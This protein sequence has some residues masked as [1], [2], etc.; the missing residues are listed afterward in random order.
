MKPKEHLDELRGMIRDTAVG[1]CQILQAYDEECLVGFMQ[2]SWDGF[3]ELC[4][5]LER[6]TASSACKQSDRSLTDAKFE[7]HMLQPKMTEREAKAKKCLASNWSMTAF[8]DALFIF[9]Q[10]HWAIEED[11]TYYVAGGRP[12][13]A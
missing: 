7:F 5:N 10:D 13:C 1:V 3:N 2:E 4:E 9:I 8:D 11:E 6:P 12:R